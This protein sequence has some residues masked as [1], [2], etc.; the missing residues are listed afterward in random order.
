M[1]S[2]RSRIR[3]LRALGVGWC[4]RAAFRRPP[5]SVT[6]SF[7]SKA[8]GA[9]RCPRVEHAP[10]T[11]LEALDLPGFLVALEYDVKSY[12]DQQ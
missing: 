2:R 11:V 5:E 6:E 8:P 10:R 3:P 7:I 4:G 1:T 9:G 12:G